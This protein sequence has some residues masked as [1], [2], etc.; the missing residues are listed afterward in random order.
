M[1]EQ[2]VQE[3]QLEPDIEELASVNADISGGLKR[4]RDMV[5]DYRSAF[6]QGQSPASDAHDVE[7]GAVMRQ[8][9]AA[10]TALTS[11]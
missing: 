3:Q 7:N 4:C 11:D 2:L 9:S 6:L 8:A 10:G 1:S 5:A